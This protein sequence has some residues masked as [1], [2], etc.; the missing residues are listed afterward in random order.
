MKAS[1]RLAIGT[2]IGGISLIFAFLAVF[3]G[4]AWIGLIVAI[5]GL[6]IFKLIERGVI[7]W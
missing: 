2:G 6:S 5:V 1:D 7:K 3:S 4:N